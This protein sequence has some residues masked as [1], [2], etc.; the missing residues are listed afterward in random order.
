MPD[1]A[2]INGRI[3]NLQDPAIPATDLA[4]LRGCGGFETL[5]TYNGQP[6]ALAQHLARLWQSAALFGIAPMASE[7]EVREWL[8]AARQQSG[9]A[10]LRINAVCS[11]GDHTEGVFGCHHPRLVLIIRQ[12]QEPPG[13]WYSAGVSA[14]SHRGERPFPE[15]KT[16]NYLCGLQALQQAGRE[17]AHEALYVDAEGRVREG[18][19]SNVHARFGDT[20]ISPDQGC[21]LGITRSGLQHVAQTAGL[22][23]QG[24]PGIP[25]AELQ[26]ADEVW[27]SSAVRELVPV[28]AIDGQPIADGRPGIWAQRLGAAYRQACENDA[29]IDAATCN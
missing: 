18:V 14:I 1:L 10:E 29:A 20:I 9:Y 7:R 15:H 5:R 21:L 27:I 28:V 11:P 2:I 13:D 8:G 26:R 12:L 25:L 19:T 3:Q 22:S 24:G 16:V 17:G 6:H 23:W 4:F